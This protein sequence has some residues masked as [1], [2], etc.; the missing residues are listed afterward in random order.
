MF[1]LCGRNYIVKL[2]QVTRVKTFYSNNSRGSR[3]HTG[4]NWPG[5]MTPTQPTCPKILNSIFFHKYWTKKHF[6]CCEMTSAG[7]Q[8]HQLGAKR[9]IFKYQRTIIAFNCKINCVKWLTFLWLV[10]FLQIFGWS[11]EYGWIECLS[12]LLLGL[13]VFLAIDGQRLNLNL[14][15]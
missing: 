3:N 2:C 13:L 12:T 4:G 6:I 1:A 10:L 14:S 11:L 15:I 5:S 8:K 7:S 9:T